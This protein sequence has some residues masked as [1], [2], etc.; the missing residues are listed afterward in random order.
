MIFLIFSFEN[1]KKSS[2][3]QTLVI[4]VLHWTDCVQFL[5]GDV[6]SSA[7]LRSRRHHRD[8]AK[9]AGLGLEHEVLDELLLAEN[10]LNICDH[11]NIIFVLKKKICQLHGWETEEIVAL[12]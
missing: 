12:E 1:M 9:L 11:M 2:S 5:F 8:G 10:H 7:K 4:L 6:L 3:C